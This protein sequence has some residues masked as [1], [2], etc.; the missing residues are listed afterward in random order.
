MRLENA[1]HRRNL[2][3]SFFTDCTIVTTHLLTY[4][5]LIYFSF[6]W[7]IAFFITIIIY[8]FLQRRLVSDFFSQ[9]SLTIAVIKF[10]ACKTRESGNFLIRPFV[11]IIILS[12]YSILIA[13]QI[14]CQSI[15]RKSVQILFCE[16][17]AE[18]TI[19]V[20]TTLKKKVSIYRP[21]FG[22]VPML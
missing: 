21:D 20:Y 15:C 19:I 2:I 22:T 18:V 9:E 13:H 1:K 3:F 8:L 12:K 6:N 5:Y 16:Q 10:I 14:A 17:E 7:A 4:T 11:I